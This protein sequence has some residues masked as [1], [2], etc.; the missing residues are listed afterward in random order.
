MAESAAGKGPLPPGVLPPSI[1]SHPALAI[2][3][4][5]I[6]ISRRSPLLLDEPEP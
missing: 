6:Q 1:Q 4:L 3:S 2:E 5:S